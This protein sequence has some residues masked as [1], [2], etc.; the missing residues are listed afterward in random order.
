MEDPLSVIP[1]IKLD[2]VGRGLGS[3]WFIRMYCP[4]HTFI[5]PFTKTVRNHRVPKGRLGREMH[6]ISRTVA[7]AIYTVPSKV[8]G[9]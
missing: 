8:P 2:N 7:E 6:T 1:R 9:A 3:S 5:S 4:F